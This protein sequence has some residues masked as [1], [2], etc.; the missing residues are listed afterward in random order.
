MGSKI[1]SL[2]HIEIAAAMATLETSI[3]FGYGSPPPLPRPATSPA[4]AAETRCHIFSCGSIHRA[5]GSLELEEEALPSVRRAVRML[6]RHKELTLSL[7][8]HCGLEMGDPH[9]RHFTRRRAVG[10]A[11]TVITAHATPLPALV[12]RGDPYGVMEQVEND[13][14]DLVQLAVKRAML[15]TMEM[16][17]EEEEAAAETVAQSWAA[18][19]SAADPEAKLLALENMASFTVHANK[20]NTLPG[21][22][23]PYATKEDKEECGEL[24]SRFV[25]YL[26]LP[27]RTPD[28][29]SVS[30]YAVLPALDVRYAQYAAAAAA[31]QTAG[32]G[33]RAV[34]VRAVADG[35]GARLATRAWGN[36]RPLVWGFGQTRGGAVTAPRPAL[37]SM[38]SP[39]MR[40]G[41]TRA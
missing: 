21:S 14:T 38:G 9:G 34:E 20:G 3:A 5:A 16:L 35:L 18:I 23:N 25:A 32:V 8:A 22:A 41:A 7:E 30:D 36:T 11:G 13:S 31:R 12:D 28:L 33:A 17:A 37:L 26:G 29:C 15:E 10:E 1:T 24:R 6:K 2:E 4:H 39:R 19:A 27:P 40:V